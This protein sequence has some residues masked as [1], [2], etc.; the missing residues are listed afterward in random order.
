MILALT[1]SIDIWSIITEARI[2]RL[3]GEFGVCVWITTYPS[4]T[5]Q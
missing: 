3:E 5:L 2:E 4:V 1:S